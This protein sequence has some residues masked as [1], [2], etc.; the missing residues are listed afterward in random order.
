MTIDTRSGTSPRLLAR[1]A[2]LL[3]LVIIALGLTGELVVRS[4]IVSPGDATAT[5]AQIAASGGLFRVGFLADS[6]MFLCDVA[7]AVLLYVLLRPVNKTI[8]LMAMCF[9]LIQTAVIAANL[10]HYH[11]AVIALSGSEYASAFGAEQLNALASFFLD[12]HSHGYDL[13]LL[14][15][16]L[17]CLLLGYLVYRS[18][19]LPRF[20]GVLL[21][22]AGFT[23]LTG[24][25]TR[26]LFPAH[27]RAVAPIYLVAIVAELSMCL[28]LLTKGVKVKE[29]ERAVSDRPAGV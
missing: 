10:L 19:Y 24:S 14:P 8:S 18:R 15:F 11:A 27:V 23:Y 4:S 13:G 9:R 25:Y 20:V 21:V 16:G 26:F 28:W 29:W 12:L 5:A 2:G 3:Y 22:A 7:L 17:S 1:T 6:V